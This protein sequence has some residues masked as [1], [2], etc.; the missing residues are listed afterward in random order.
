MVGE[1]SASSQSAITPRRIRECRCRCRCRG[2][3]LQQR[4][5]AYGCCLIR[6]EHIVETG[7]LSILGYIV[8]S[9]T[10]YFNHFSTSNELRNQTS[11]LLFTVLLVTYIPAIVG[12]SIFGRCAPEKAGYFAPGRFRTVATVLGVVFWLTLAAPQFAC[13]LSSI[14]LETEIATKLGQ[15]SPASAAAIPVSFGKWMFRSTSEWGPYDSLAGNFSMETH[16]YMTGLEWR[17]DDCKA[18]VNARRWADHL[19]LDVYFPAKRAQAL[20]P[21]I[22]WIHAG[23]WK[24]RDK[25]FIKWSPA[26]FLDRGYAVVSLQFTYSCWGFIVWE[27]LSQMTAALDYVRANSSSWGFDKDRIFVSGASSGGHL[28]IMLAYTFKSPVC[29]NWSSCGIKGVLDLYGAKDLMWIGDLASKVI[30]TPL[31][32]S[33]KQEDWEAVCPI[34]LVSE[35]SPPTV[36]IHGTWDYVIDFASSVQFHKKLEQHGVRHLLVG[37]PTFGHDPEAGY[38]GAPAQIHRFVLERFVAMDLF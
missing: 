38:W 28:A 22:V 4:S 17:K 11:G 21:I 15:S 12:G 10:F 29:G 23:A 14:G 37:L 19:D 1:S 27:M 35:T 6:L 31:T 24:Q 7:I 36:T 20:A 30:F 3:C 34:N 32:N 13:M 9:S 33:S 2:P 5:F 8:L 25:D 16:T 18:N 26:Y